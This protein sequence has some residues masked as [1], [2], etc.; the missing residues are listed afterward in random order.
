[1][2]AK[3]RAELVEKTL[4]NLGVLAA[5]QSPQVEDT[6]RVT[7][8]LDALMAEFKEREIVDVPADVIPLAYFKPLAAMVAY[9]CRG[10][11]GVG[12]EE[13]AKLKNAND[14]AI[15]KLKVMTRVKPTGEPVQTTWI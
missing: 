9:E 4:E 7:N 13:E 12:L 2:A 1:M 11:F 5:G 15:M 10:S 14:E 6:A 8:D 3:T